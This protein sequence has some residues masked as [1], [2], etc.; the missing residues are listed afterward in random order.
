MRLGV[1]MVSLIA[2]N[3]SLTWKYSVNEKPCLREMR[4]A[5]SLLQ[6]TYAS[7]MCLAK[8]A[9]VDPWKA[10]SPQSDGVSGRMAVCTYITGKTAS[11]SELGSLAQ[12]ATG[13][14]HSGQAI[15]S[16]ISFPTSSSR[17]LSDKF[18]GNIR[19]LS[20]WFTNNRIKSTL[21]K[22]RE[23]EASIFLSGKSSSALHCLPGACPRLLENGL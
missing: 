9:P 14:L 3:I 21:N 7:T 11:S 13:V 17:S 4:I 6:E 16:I 8:S 2:F 15:I 22:D 20:A 5:T 10:L 18:S 19:G 23:N 12:E 1:R